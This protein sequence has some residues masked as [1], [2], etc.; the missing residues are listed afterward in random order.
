[1]N[2]IIVVSLVTLILYISGL[3]SPPLSSG[4]LHD[5]VDENGLMLEKERA[6]GT[7]GATMYT[8]DVRDKTV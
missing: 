1:M 8:L 6:L 5:T 2:V 3:L 7:V 4:V